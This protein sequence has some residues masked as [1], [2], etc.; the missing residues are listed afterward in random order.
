MATGITTCT[1]QMSLMTTPET[2]C[3]LETVGI[4]TVLAATM[5]ALPLGQVCSHAKKLACEHCGMDS[6]HMQYHLF[7]H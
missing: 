1:C 4:G 2:F 7:T 3:V 5:V 6:I